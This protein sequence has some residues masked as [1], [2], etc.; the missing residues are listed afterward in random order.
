V[1]YVS[2]I[3]GQPTGKDGDGTIAR[4]SARGEVLAL[5]WA[6]GLDAPK[7]MGLVGDTLWVTDIDR[8]HAVDSGSGRILR[9]VPAPGAKFLNDIAVG[10]GGEVYVS[11]MTTGRIHVLRGDT[12]PVLADLSGLKGSNG[13]LMQ[14]GSLLVGTATGIARVEPATGRAELFVPLQGFGMIDGLRAYGPGAYLVSDW[15]G[16]TQIVRTGGPA[17]LLLDTTAQKI[18]SADFEYVEA[19]RTLLIPTFT[20]NRVVAYRLEP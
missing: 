20:D 19:T 16:R 14:G 3:R 7:G 13:L 2:C 17:T 6:R 8:L 4:L 1:F 15:A 10:P 18:R 12:L 9:T 11:D 5:G